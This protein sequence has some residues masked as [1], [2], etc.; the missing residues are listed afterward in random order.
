MSVRLAEEKD[1]ALF[2]EWV[3]NTPLNLFQPNAGLDTYPSLKTF[4]VERGG[5]PVLFAPMHPVLMVESLAHAPN[6]S[7]Y[8][9]AMALAELQSQMDRLARQYKLAEIWWGCKDESL[10]KYATGRA[11]YERIEFPMLKKVVPEGFNDYRKK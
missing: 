3:L 10:I 5:R 11:H 2:A 9:N 8:D 4:V 1:A 7:R 6:V